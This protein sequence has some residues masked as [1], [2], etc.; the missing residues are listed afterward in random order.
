[1]KANHRAG[2]GTPWICDT[3]LFSFSKK[4]ILGG[5]RQSFSRNTTQDPEYEDK[6]GNRQDGRNLVEEWLELHEDENSQYIW[7]K[8]GFDSVDYTQVDY[9]LGELDLRTI[10]RLCALENWTL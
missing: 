10:I 7:N 3:M 4:V 6:T 5:G 2:E 9:L 1:M 8:D